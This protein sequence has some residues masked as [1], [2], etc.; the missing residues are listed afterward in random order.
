MTDTIQKPSS[1]G[2][3]DD[4]VNHFRALHAPEADPERALRE[5]LRAF[6]RDY[7]REQGTKG[8]TVKAMQQRLMEAKLRAPQDWP[9]SKDVLARLL[10]DCVGPD[11]LPPLMPA[12]QMV[13]LGTE[14]GYEN[15]TI[16]AAIFR[17]FPAMTPDDAAGAYREAAEYFREEVERLKVESAVFHAWTNIERA[18]GR[19]ENELVFGNFCHEL[20]IVT[21]DRRI[22]F[23]RLKDVADPEMREAT[24]AALLTTAHTSPAPAA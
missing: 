14:C 7:L 13:W 12:A 6:V 8:A 9:Q 22:D 1:V 21:P 15:E 5:R 24:L 4:L 2:T 3:A 20:D 16:G 23:A 11:R 19:S 10:R 17:L 18:R